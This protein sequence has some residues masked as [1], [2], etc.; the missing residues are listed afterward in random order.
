M[1]AEGIT[2]PDGLYQLVENFERNRDAYRS[3]RYNETQVRVDFINPLFEVLGWDVTN[4]QGQ[5]PAYQDVVH[6]DA[7]K[8][9]GAH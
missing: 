5:M 8:V 4:R 2:A 7:I 1:N 9:G 6:E 3:G